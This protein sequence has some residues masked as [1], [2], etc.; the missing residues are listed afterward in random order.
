MIS[1]TPSGWRTSAAVPGRASGAPTRT[2]CIHAGE[3]VEGVVD[4]ADREA[5]SVV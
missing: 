5:V 2:G 3:V 1:T 4:L